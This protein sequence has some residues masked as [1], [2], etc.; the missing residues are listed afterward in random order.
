MSIAYPTTHWVHEQTPETKA[1]ETQ[2]ALEQLAQETPKGTPNG[3]VPDWQVV[4]KHPVP[5]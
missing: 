4:H 3:A 1:T 5:L 2:F